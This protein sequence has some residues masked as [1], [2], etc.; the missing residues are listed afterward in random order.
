MYQISLPTAARA[1]ASVAAKM[2][3][4]ILDLP[5]SMRNGYDKVIND[6]ANESRIMYA[7]DRL[8]TRRITESD[9]Y[10]A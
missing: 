5:V 10:Y 1:S 7:A 9:Y 2:R 4:T 3:E 6:L 8:H